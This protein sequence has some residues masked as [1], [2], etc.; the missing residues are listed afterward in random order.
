[1]WKAEFAAAVTHKTVFCTGAP[2]AA[3][4]QVLCGAQSDGF[5]ATT[6][7]SQQ[8]RG[9]ACASAS[10]CRGYFKAASWG[11]RGSARNTLV[12]SLSRRGRSLGFSYETESQFYESYFDAYRIWHITSTTPFSPASRSLPARAPIPVSSLKSSIHIY[13]KETSAGVYVL[14]MHK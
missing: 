10:P 2:L 5:N 4:R 12:S 3:V 1:M 11:A 13:C 14:Y 8:R 7:S 6:A 9:S